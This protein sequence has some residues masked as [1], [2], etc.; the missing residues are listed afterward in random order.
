MQI[1]N[2]AQAGIPV[3]SVVGSLDATTTAD[4]D[5][6]WKKVLDA[7]EKRLI[8]DLAGVDYISSAGLRGILMLAKVAKVAKVQSAAIAF[9]GMQGMVADMFKLSGFASIL[10]IYPDA[11]TA[12]VNFP[13][14]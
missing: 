3:L 6:E 4:F 9:C 8:V 14:A 10:A 5:A 13:Q 7:G 1:T 2:T 12:A 11:P